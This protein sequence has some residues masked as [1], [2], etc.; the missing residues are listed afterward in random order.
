MTCPCAMHDRAAGARRNW[1]T[2]HGVAQQRKKANGR[3]RMTERLTTAHPYLAN[4][5]WSMNR[6]IPLATASPHTPNLCVLT[7]GVAWHIGC[8][9]EDLKNSND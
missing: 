5:R 2:V 4:S 1:C 6:A 8:L 7:H 3:K 9:I